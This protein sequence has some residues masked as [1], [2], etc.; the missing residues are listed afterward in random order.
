MT[1][2]AWD[3]RYI[4]SDSQSEYGGLLGSCAKLWRGTDYDPGAVVGIVGAYRSS[5]L[6]ADWFATGADR[7]AFPKLLEVDRDCAGVIVV[8][9]ELLV[10]TFE[11]S[12]CPIEEQLSIYAWGSGGDMAVGAMEHG[13]SAME[14]CAIAC[15]RMSG[16]GGN[17]MYCDMAD[18]DAKLAVWKP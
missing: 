11:G 8:D 14:A 2:I 7:G 1:V 16:C 10:T 6:V 12:P 15:R 3:G 17:I 4:A 5:K 13:A 18:P 9:S